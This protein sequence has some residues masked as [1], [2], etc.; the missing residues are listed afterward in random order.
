MEHS[1][2]RLIDLGGFMISTEPRKN[3]VLISILML[4][5]LIGIGFRLEST[6][7]DHT[8]SPNRVETFLPR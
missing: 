4:L 7:D 6:L 5:T 1:V 3:L 8:E 2:I